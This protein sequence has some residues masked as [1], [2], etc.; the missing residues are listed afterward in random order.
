[1]SSTAAR[2]IDLAS[3]LLLGV[4][5]KSLICF[6]TSNNA[7][8]RNDQVLLYALETRGRPN[9]SMAMAASRWSASLRGSGSPVTVPA[10]EERDGNSVKVVKA[11]VL[12]LYTL[13]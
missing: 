2:I 10:S 7:S 4:G 8:S 5:G 13:L 9:A 1:M 12:S 3:S 11:R 6:S